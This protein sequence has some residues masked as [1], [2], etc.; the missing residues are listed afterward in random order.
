MNNHKLRRKFCWDE[1]GELERLPMF[2][3]IL[4]IIAAI[5]IIV[6]LSWYSLPTTPHLSEIHIYIDGK[7]LDLSNVTEG[8]HDVYIIAKD[9]NDELLKDV[10]IEIIGTG[11]N[12]SKKTDTN[13]KADFGSLTFELEGIISD[14]VFIHA[15]YKD[16]LPI[17]ESI[18]VL[19]S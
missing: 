9:N 17:H 16:S 7:Q 1:K 6:I 3:I 19:K 18:W 14:V 10:L 4:V 12:M 15:S 13:G 2:L 11:I 5:V 8:T